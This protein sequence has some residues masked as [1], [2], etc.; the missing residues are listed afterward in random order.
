L[1]ELV[2]SHVLQRSGSEA[3]FVEDKSNFIISRDALDAQFGKVWKLAAELPGF[4]GL[5]P[6][7]GFA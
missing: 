5:S 2:P 6:L 3:A 1:L 7:D 4:A